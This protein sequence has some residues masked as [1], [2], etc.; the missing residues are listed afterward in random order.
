LKNISQDQ[1]YP[2]KLH[3]LI[4]LRNSR[5]TSHTEKYSKILD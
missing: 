5:R 1:N 2:V 3:Q 4:P